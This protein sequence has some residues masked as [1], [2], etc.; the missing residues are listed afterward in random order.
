M[1]VL[2]LAINKPVA[3]KM[4]LDVML[5]ETSMKTILNNIYVIT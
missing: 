3:I 4:F 2:F 1:G 5:H